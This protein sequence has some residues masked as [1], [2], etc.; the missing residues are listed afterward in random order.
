MPGN[1][2][3]LLG[4][5]LMVLREEAGLTQEKLAE[6]FHT[7]KATISRYETGARDP[8]LDTLIDFADFF[9]VSTDYLLGRTENRKRL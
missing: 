6:I 4:K 7:K 9:N 5:R 2:R 1:K 8:K 3:N